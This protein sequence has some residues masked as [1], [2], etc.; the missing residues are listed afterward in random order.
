MIYKT[1]ESNGSYRRKLKI[2]R[3]ENERYHT[4]IKD[5]LIMSVVCII[6]IKH[7]SSFMFSP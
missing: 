2:E 1:E 3:S 4:N 5:I 7:K 6:C